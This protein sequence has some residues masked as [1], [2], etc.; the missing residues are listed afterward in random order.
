[1]GA[2]VAE[3]SD[4]P[5]WTGKLEWT[6]ETDR[7]LR[8]A[9]DA[10]NQ[11]TGDKTATSEAA[12]W[13]EDY[14]ASQDGHADAAEIKRKGAA[15][16]HSQSALHRARHA[17]SVSVI[18]SGFPRRSVW[19]LQSSRARGE[20]SNGMNEM[21]GTTNGQSSQSSH[22]FQSSKGRGSETKGADDVDRL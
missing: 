13:L 5:V 20:T 3:T 2:K 16:G 19:N 12:G 7:T 10:A 11:T 9:L 15:A 8:D 1:M 18:T 6:G 21:N 22:S 17:L 4:G 14:L